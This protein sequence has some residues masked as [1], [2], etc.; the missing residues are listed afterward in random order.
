M[1]EDRFLGVRLDAEDL[2]R[3]DRMVQERGFSNRSE[4]IRRILRESVDAGIPAR[5]P[6]ERV[7]RGRS[8][9][10]PPVLFRELE[11]SVENGYS[12]A[13][14]SALEKAIERG[15]E[16]LARQ[17]SQRVEL[18]RATAQKLAQED[19]DQRRASREGERHGGK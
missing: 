16:E 5:A 11:R 6:G 18:E 14:E 13:V 3:L 17:R 9:E 2:E 4:A 10:V 8:V 7:P 12:S 19:A 1:G 15:L